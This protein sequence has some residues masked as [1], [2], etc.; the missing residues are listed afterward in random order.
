MSAAG[1][2]DLGDGIVNRLLSRDGV[3]ERRS[4]FA[5]RPAL[6]VAGKEFFHLDEPG[7]ADV[8]LGRKVIQA[9][10]DELRSDPRIELRSNASDWIQ[11]RFASETEADIVLRW[12]EIALGS[13][14]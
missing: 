5:D 7:L 14:P 12:A 6:F 4:K 10:R 8:R 11:V 9:H 1:L 13:T 3:E 2:A